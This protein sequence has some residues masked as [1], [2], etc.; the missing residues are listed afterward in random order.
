[1]PLTLKKQECKIMQ[2]KKYSIWRTVKK[3]KGVN[4]KPKFRTLIDDTKKANDDEKSE[5]I[6]YQK[7]LL[8]SVMMKTC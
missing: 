6:F 8:G 4:T 5:K 7:S 1:M 3:I 2:I